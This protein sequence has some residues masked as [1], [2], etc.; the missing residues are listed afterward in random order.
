M[1]FKEKNSARSTKL[2]KGKILEQV[3]HFTYLGCDVSFKFHKD[4]EKKVDIF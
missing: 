1:A 2:I 4:V 3:S